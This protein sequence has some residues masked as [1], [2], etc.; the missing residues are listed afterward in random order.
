MK[1]SKEKCITCAHF[2]CAQRELNYWESTGFCTNNKFKFNTVDGRLIGVYD[3]E[4]LRDTKTITGNPSHNIE[5]ISHS[6]YS[7]SESRYVLQ[8]GENFG[9]IYHEVKIK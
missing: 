6:P 9:C 4:N 7:I 3:K 1:A 8:V 5:T 2:K